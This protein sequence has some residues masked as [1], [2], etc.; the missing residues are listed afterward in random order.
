MDFLLLAH[1]VL[2]VLLLISGVAKLRDRDATADAFEAL[3]LPSWLV[4]AGAPLLL[5]VAELVLAALLVLGRG[6]LLTAA[7]VAVL[8]LMLAYTVVIA[9]ALGF[10]EPVR[11]GCFG[12]LGSGDVTRATLVRN[13]LL[14]AL[15]ALS[16]AGAVWGVAT[17]G[18]PATSWGWVLVALLSAAA[19]ALSLGGGAAPASP[20]SMEWIQGASLIDESN[21]QT[22]RVRE[23]AGAHGGVALLFVLPG[24]GGC[25]RALAELPRLRAANPER[26]VVP[27]I[28]GWASIDEELAAVPDLHR[29]P[30]SNVAAALGMVYAP[31][32]LVVDASGRPVGEFHTG[33][34]A[35]QQLFE[36]GMDAEPHEPEPAPADDPAAAVPETVEEDELDYVRSPIP[37]GVVLD[38]DGAP[39]TLRQLAGEKAQL[40]VA[41]DCLCPPARMA[42]DS[43]VGWQEKLPMLDV[44]LV[45]PFRMQPGRLTPEQ[46]RLALY[47]HGGLATR[48]LGATG[49]VAAVLLGA[50]GMLAGGPVHGI[51]EVRGFVDDIADEIAAASAV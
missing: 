18:Q 50:D 45:L 1:V 2:A 39:S 15:A 6:W 14:V 49:Q 5:P 51:D 34:P 13:V 20:G 19:V 8:V 24:C 7:T 12:A 22:V 26:F 27:V 33:G 40:L 31:S 42:M 32:A 21:G 48:S 29:D 11:C 10:D 28:P 37:D 16:V 44:R 36:L 3:R 46:E 38:P 23:L 47:D 30:G 9:R 41:V 17:W 35:V 4:G 43:V 25:R